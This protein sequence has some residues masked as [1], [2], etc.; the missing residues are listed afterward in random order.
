MEHVLKFFHFH[1]NQVFL[2]FFVACH[3][4]LFHPQIFIATNI[5]FHF[6]WFT[7]LVQIVKVACKNDIIQQIFWRVFNFFQL[8]SE[9]SHCD[10]YV[11]IENWSDS[12]YEEY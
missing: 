9:W 5:C 7:G 4:G 10:M 2:I 1:K 6:P 12:I 8:L 3:G 11:T